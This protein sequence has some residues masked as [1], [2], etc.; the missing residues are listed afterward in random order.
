MDI[1]K[2]FLIIISL[3]S[4][5]YLNFVNKNSIPPE[6]RSF[7]K[8]LYHQTN[9]CL[10]LFGGINQKQRFN[11][12]WAFY[13]SSATWERI[14]SSKELQPSERQNPLFFKSIENNHTLYVFGG[15]DKHGS[16]ADLWE[17]SL[18]NFQWNFIEEFQ[19]VGSRVYT[20]MTTG[21][22]ENVQKIIIVG[23]KDLNYEYYD[24]FL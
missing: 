3:S 10:Y 24:I 11:D 20:G 2:A 13:F 21:I 4:G 15:N 12:L 22:L 23:G 18:I 17:F 5:K 1:I 8:I 14:E 7:C 19:D 6:K 16:R 9:N